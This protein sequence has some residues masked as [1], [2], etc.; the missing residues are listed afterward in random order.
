MADL[1][2][3]LKWL[4]AKSRELI[5]RCVVEAW[6]GTQLYT[7]DGSGGYPALWVRDFSDLVEYAWP[8]LD[9][10]KASDNLMLITENQRMNGAIPDRIQ[11]NGLAVFSPGPVEDPFSFWPALDN[12]MY[13]VIAACSMARNLSQ[14][15][16]IYHLGDLLVN[17]LHYV[18]RDV[19]G[20]VWVDPEHPRSGYGYHDAL[21]KTGADLFCSLLWWQA[22]RSFAREAR[23]LGPTLNQ[24]INDLE[25]EARRVES[26]VG[27]L[28]D[29]D[30]GAFLAA[31]EQCRQIDV[32]GSLYA[33]YIDF[34]L[35]S[36]RDRL[37]EFL[38]QNLERYTWRGQVRHLLKDEY[39]QSARIEPGQ[40]QN[41]A[42][43]AH[44][45]GWCFHA[46]AQA[47]RARAERFMDELVKYLRT[48]GAY[49]CVT[50]S[51]RKLEGFVSS[52]AVP[53]GVLARY[54]ESS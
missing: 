54:L 31:G 13:F 44:A 12:Q 50:E 4:E 27:A 43:W 26:A 34:P 41:G 32:W 51:D 15:Q 30:R 33:V 11:P 52:A 8:L 28:W 45:S 42:Y 22:A 9:K 49:E 36:R 24:H 18:S 23:K 46:L 35:G 3:H 47:D 48:E 6:D 40:Y 19:D 38:V 1:R 14:P 16:M 53:Y 21:N 25:S 17:A 29:A 20:L 39:W 7:P 37:I 10:E 5:D 2:E